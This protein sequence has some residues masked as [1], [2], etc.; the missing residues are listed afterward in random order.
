MNSLKISSPRFVHCELLKYF[1]SLRYL[2]F[3]K[4]FKLFKSFEFIFFNRKNFFV[5]MSEFKVDKETNADKRQYLSDM[6]SHH[7]SE[8]SRLERC[9]CGGE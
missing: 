5:T 8:L 4:Y 9:L 6:L 1:I 7:D 3:S 2:K